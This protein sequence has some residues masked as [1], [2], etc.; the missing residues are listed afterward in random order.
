MHSKRQPGSEAHLVTLIV[1]PILLTAACSRPGDRPPESLAAWETVET[2]LRHPRCLN[3]HQLD[4]PL[5]GDVPRR[6]VP[7]AVRGSDNHGV[8][9][10]RCGNCH[11]Q[12]GNNETS[13][14]PGAPHWQLSPVSMVWEGL[15]SADLCESLKDPARNG[16]RSD[17]DLVEHMSADPLVL[18]GWQPGGT[19]EPVP[20]PHD[21]FVRILTTWVETGSHCPST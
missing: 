3:C 5:Q 19:R 6:H 11:N 16:N 8:S 9:A 2:V 21:R 4:A 20:V 15:S 7:R 18:W 14:T 17:E 12:M 13:G 10:M 1:L